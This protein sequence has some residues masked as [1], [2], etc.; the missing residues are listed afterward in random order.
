MFCK[1]LLLVG[2]NGALFGSTAW[3][4]YSCCL[5]QLYILLLAMGDPPLYGEL[6]YLHTAKVHAS[7]AESEDFDFRLTAKNQIS[8]S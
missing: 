8:R 4:S 5:L 7:R 2:Q 6:A 3:W 1:V